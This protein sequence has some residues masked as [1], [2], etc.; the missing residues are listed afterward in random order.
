MKSI[1]LRS[2]FFT[3]IFIIILSGTALAAAWENYTDV[4]DH[5]AEN[6][7]QKGFNDGLITGIDEATI[8]PDAPITSAQMITILCRVLGAKDTADIS[9]LG[10]TADAWYADAAGKALNLGLISAGNVNLEAPMSRQDALTMMAKAFCLVPAESDLTVLNAFSDASNISAKN[11]NAMAALVS[12][13]LIAGFN[14]SLSVTSN[15]TRAEFLTVLYRVASN[16]ISA[17]SFTSGQAGGSVVKGSGTVSSIQTSN[18]WFDCSSENISISGL[19]ADSLTLRSHSLKSF[20]M[21]GNNTISKLAVAVGKGK[22]SFGANGNAKVGL[23]QLDACEGADVGADVNSIEIIGNGIPVSISGKHDYLIITGNSNVITLSPDVSLSRLKITGENNSVVIKDSNPNILS[24]DVIEILGK[25]NSVAISIPSDKAT[26]LSINGVGNKI[27]SQSGRITDLEVTGIKS[28]IK[29]SFITDIS[30]INVTGNENTL[31]II[32]AS[33]K[34]ESAADAAS[35]AEASSYDFV[36]SATVSGNSNWV[37]LSC[38][39][40][41][42]LKISGNYN[43]INKLGIGNTKSVELPG[44]QNAFV[45]KEGGQLQ[46][47]NISGSS[48]LITLN[49]TAQNIIVAGSKTNLSGSCKAQNLTINAYGCNIGI[50]AVNITD[51][52]SQAE[53]DRVLKLVT[54]GYKGN[55]TLQW[56]LEHDYQTF[57]KEIWVNAK[58][59][60]SNTNYLIWVN[61][62]MQRVNIFKSSN[63]KWELCHSCVVGTGAPSTGTPVGVW[64]TTYKSWAGWTTS[65]YTVKPVVGFKENT[66]YAFHSRLYA[67]STTNISD[68]SI[69]YPVSHGCVRMYDADIKY[70]Y[71]NIPLGTTVVVY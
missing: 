34:P 52:S 60:T 69:G 9:K 57:E 17:D 5:W 41:A 61:L 3:F 27:S 26:K 25:A 2:A 40:I 39:N 62:S 15:I 44:S 70:I 7:L 48:N 12:K 21:N 20:N 68:A 59:Y 10:I 16:Y 47:A 53:I 51:N 43:T 37:T 18:I 6:T 36:N 1:S 8:A 46:D 29:V 14:G 49:G 13:K 33:E 45:I 71:D 54:L 30:S 63:G 19:S 28:D 42:S 56:A 4:S 58:G 24:C 11:K 32:C 23:L 31:Q 50:S 66:G 38:K 55:F 22:V 35:T 65:T 67:P 64:R